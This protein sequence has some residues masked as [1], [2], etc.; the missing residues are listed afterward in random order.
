[1][2]CATSPLSNSAQPIGRA[3]QPAEVTAAVLRQIER[4]NPAV[5]AFVTVVA[6]KA[7][8]A[9]E[10]ADARLASGRVLG[11]LDGVPVGINDLADTAAMRTTHGSYIYEH[12]VPDTDAPVVAKM[13]QAGAIIQGKTNTPEFGW[14]SPTNNPLFGPTR[15][16]WN[17]E[18]TAAGSSGGSAAAVAFE[19]LQPWANRR[20]PVVA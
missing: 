18:R 1:M 20:P 5:N 10:A 17:T 16:P 9:A 2:H 8:A 15:N 7:M 11:P 6:D 14:K 19:A 12:H 4:V 13:K 3:L